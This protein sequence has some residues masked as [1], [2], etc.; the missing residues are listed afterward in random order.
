M[1]TNQS[2]FTLF[3]LFIC[4]VSCVG[5][6]QKDKN[7]EPKTLIIGHRSTG[8]GVNEGF[9]ENT[10]PAAKEALLYIDGVE[11]DIQLSSSLT[12]WIYHDD[13]F[14]HLCGET[15][16]ILKAEGYTC[17]VNTP[18]SIIEKILICQEG[19]K[20]RIYKLE[21]LFIELAKDKD[22]IVSL[23]IKGYYDSTCV[24]TKNVGWDYLDNLALA[25]YHLAKTYKVIPQIIIETDYDYIFQKI[26]ELDKDIAC[27]FMIYNN[28]ADKIDFALELE[29][30]GITVNM[31][32]ESFH[33]DEIERA[34]RE[35][36]KVQLWIAAI[37][38][39]LS[40]ALKYKPYAI[41]LS[42][43]NLI[44]SYADSIPHPQENKNQLSN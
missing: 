37:Q 16:S 7:A 34:K 40:T 23:D 36:L 28:L 2:L 1:R 32:D 17:I 21:E 27:H 20:D 41:Q 5:I 6:S 33:L 38:E 18:D 4:T 31:H 13:L 30:D 24:N 15:D 8:T 26:K 19:A 9:I 43:L 42:N 11:A 29:V 3:L 22:K 25:I 44:R 35:G 10:L 39:H 12:P 14:H